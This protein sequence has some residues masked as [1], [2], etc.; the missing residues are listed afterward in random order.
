M[1]KKTTA[2]ISLLILLGGLGFLSMRRIERTLV[3]EWRVTVLD[4]LQKPVK[5]IRVSQSCDDYTIGWSAGG[6]S[7]TDALG[8]V[9]FPRRSLNVTRFYW[10]LAPVVT[11]LKYGVHASTGVFAIV[12]VSDP[13]HFDSHASQ[14][15]DNGC[16][17]QPMHSLIRVKP[18]VLQ[19][20]SASPRGEP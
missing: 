3:E 18:G 13:R 11:R 12:S 2:V 7:Y 1:L 15:S 8:R 14:C 6:D 17:R 19:P 20:A 9:T 10:A 4:E 16:S 5:G